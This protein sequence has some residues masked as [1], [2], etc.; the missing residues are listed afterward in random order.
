[1]RV[2]QHE[3]LVC[4]L[5]ALLVADYKRTQKSET[6][7]HAGNVTAVNAHDERNLDEP[8]QISTRQA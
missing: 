7:D 6:A 8:I 5:A 4:A 3:A 1:V 2:G